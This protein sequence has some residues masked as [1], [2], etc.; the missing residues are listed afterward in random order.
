MLEANVIRHETA[1][2]DTQTVAITLGIKVEKKPLLLVKPASIES[3]A[4]SKI[5]I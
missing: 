5:P 4:H 1:Y 2:G 3:A